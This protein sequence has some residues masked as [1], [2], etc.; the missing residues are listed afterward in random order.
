M[1]LEADQVRG[2][3]ITGETSTDELRRRINDELREDLDVRLFSKLVTVLF[4]TIEQG[5]IESIEELKDTFTQVLDALLLQQDY[6]TINQ[7]LVKL[8]ALERNSSLADTATTLRTFF[9]GKMAETQRLHAIGETLQGGRPKNVQDIF[10]YLMALDSH[11]VVPLLEMLETLEIAENRQLVCDALAALG[12]D[13]PDPFVNRLGSE[14]SQTVRDMLYVIDKC[15]FP[16]KLKIFATALKNTN[17]AVRLETMGVVS[18]SRT[19]GAKKLVIEL[20]DDKAP[21]VR[22]GAAR[23]LAS[24]DRDRAAVELMG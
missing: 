6:G 17:L 24:S 4:Q 13:Q 5:G 1:K 23:A 22:L 18:R 15:D 3:V 10:R 2:A 7:V 20:L 9:V 12:K 14:K 16:D 11:A 21:Q 19:E 8:K